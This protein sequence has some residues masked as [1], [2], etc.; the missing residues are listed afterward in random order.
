MDFINIMA[1]K[2]QFI[3]CQNNELENRLKSV[4]KNIQSLGIEQPK[5]CLFNDGTCGYPINDCYNCPVHSW[6]GYVPMVKCE[7]K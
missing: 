3:Q 6:S 7:I 1:E 5:K 4:S 2:M